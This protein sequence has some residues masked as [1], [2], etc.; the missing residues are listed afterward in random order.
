MLPGRTLVP[1]LIYKIRLGIDT[2]VL[3]DCRP[4]L[5]YEQRN[6]ELS[7]GVKRRVTDHRDREFLKGFFYI[8]VCDTRHD[9]LELLAIAEYRG[10]F[11][12]EPTRISFREMIY[13]KPYKHFG[14]IIKIYT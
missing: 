13:T 3:T 2:S 12:R 11:L 10:I 1:N 6:T 7:Q 8:S 4:A 5:C 14:H 9:K